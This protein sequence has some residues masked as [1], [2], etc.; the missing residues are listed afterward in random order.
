MASQIY[1][2]AETN[3]AVKRLDEVAPKVIELLALEGVKYEIPFV[4]DL[5]YRNMSVIKAVAVILEAI[6]SQH[7]AA[8]D[9]N[10]ADNSD[11]PDG[12]GVLVNASGEVVEDGEPDGDADPATM[13]KAQISAALDVRGMEHSSRATHAELLA[14]YQQS[15][16]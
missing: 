5:G 2:R 7:S 10:D 11:E 8:L 4:R 14:L 6:A 3:N 1:I 9:A 15:E 13:T 16:E 12:D